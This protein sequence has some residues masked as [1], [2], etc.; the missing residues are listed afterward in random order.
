MP[1]TN[2]VVSNSGNSS[3]A[4]FDFTI[5]RGAT[6]ATG[7]ITWRGGW[8]SSTAYGTNEAVYYN[9]SS[10]I[11][12]ADNQNVTPGTDNTKWNIMAAA[13]A[14]GGA[15]SSMADTD[16]NPTVLNNS[17]LMYHSSSTKWKDI[18]PFGSVHGDVALQIERD[19]IQIDARARL[20]VRTH[21]AHGT[22]TRSF[23]RIRGIVRAATSTGRHFVHGLAASNP[24]QRLHLHCTC[25]VAVTRWTIASEAM[26]REASCPVPTDLVLHFAQLV[27]TCL[28]EQGAGLRELHRPESRPPVA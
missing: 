18:Q 26:R 16:I 22:C 10:Y 15:I 17:I 6:G 3:A 2:A 4:T 7:E 8:N 5:P 13:G 1:G 25:G 24:Y 20:D 28:G 19:L 11:A 23:E 12:V 27:L 9:G 14:E 21:P